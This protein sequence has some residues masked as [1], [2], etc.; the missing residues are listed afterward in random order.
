[1]TLPAEGTGLEILTHRGLALSA[2][3]AVAQAA[4]AAAIA[5]SGCVCI[6][7]VD[8]GGH[9]QHFVRMDG[10]HIAS[11]EVAIAKAR[12]ALS[13]RRPTKVFADSVAVG[14]AALIDLP[15]MIPFEGGVPLVYGGEVVGAIGVSG[16]S[17]ELDGEVGRA[18]ADIL[19]AG[20]GGER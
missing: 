6:A 20:E 1:M 17:P 12:C 16:G 9:L 3:R 5:R 19:R 13:F 14:G 2:T 15:G 7:I 10:S 8:G 4:E 11:I 18:G